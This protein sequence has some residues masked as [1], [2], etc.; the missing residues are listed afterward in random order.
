MESHEA[1][2]ELFDNKVECPECW[3]MVNELYESPNIPTSGC[4]LCVACFKNEQVDWERAG[5][6]MGIHLTQNRYFYEQEETNE[7]LESKV[8]SRD[9]RGR[10]D[11]RSLLK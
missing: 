6:G 9:S 8:R 10:G 7:S 2:K 5:L 3:A 1:N 11:P 4:F